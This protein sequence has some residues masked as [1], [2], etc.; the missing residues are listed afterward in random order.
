MRTVHTLIPI[1]AAVLALVAPTTWAGDV[2]L[3]DATFDDKTVGAP[4]GTG[5]AALGEPISVSFGIDAVVRDGIF[6]TRSL[7]IADEA[8]SGTPVV[9]FELLESAEVTEGLLEVSA[10]LRFSKIDG[11]V[12]YLREQGSSA[13]SFTN[14]TFTVAGGLTI[15]DAAGT[16]F[17]GGSYSAG[18]DHL[19]EITHNLDARTW[20]LSFDGTPLVSD[21]AHGI[22]ERGIGAVLIGIQNDAELDGSVHVDRL[23]V[24]SD[25]IVPAREAS[26]GGI[27]ATY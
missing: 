5:G 21:R 11:Y 10:S 8:T 27:K 7:E 16:A 17:T 15:T 4:I 23:R 24:T 1:T 22:T 19:L 20:D 3:L 2:A 25:K 26:W 12:F 14:V 18:V 9:R 6:D 13:S